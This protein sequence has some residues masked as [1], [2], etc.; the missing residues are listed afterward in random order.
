[1]RCD[2]CTDSTTQTYSARSPASNGTPALACPRFR[3]SQTPDTIAFLQGQRVQAQADRPLRA[4]VA[5]RSLPATRMTGRR[6]APR[7]MG[8]EPGTLAENR[9]SLGGVLLEWFGLCTRSCFFEFL[10]IRP[11]RGVHSRNHAA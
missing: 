8:L 10:A 2:P 1:M 9:V 4:V 7:Q 5:P 3:F 6:Y 11:I